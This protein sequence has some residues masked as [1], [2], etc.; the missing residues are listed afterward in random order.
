MLTLLLMLST[1]VL[2]ESYE[3]TLETRIPKWSLPVYRQPNSR[4][5]VRGRVLG[6]AAFYVIER[7]EGPG[8]DGDEGWGLI[9][10]EAFV[11]L[12]Q[13]KPT[14]AKPVPQPVLVTL[15]GSEYKV[16]QESGKE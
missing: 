3:S 9:G 10:D 2:A 12:D 16:I 15:D 7:V 11:C 5:F 4:S 14:T 8:C 6:G 13:T 1:P